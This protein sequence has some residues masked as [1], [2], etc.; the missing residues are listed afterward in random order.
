MFRLHKS[1]QHLLFLTQEQVSK[2]EKSD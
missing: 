1:R 2:F